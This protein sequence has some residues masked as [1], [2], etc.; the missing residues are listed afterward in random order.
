[1][2][3]GCIIRS[4]G[5]RTE[6]LCVEAVRRY[7]P[8]ENVDIVR[9]VRPFHMA[10]RRMFDIANGKDYDWY[11][12]LD[13]D[14]VLIDAW[15]NHVQD[16]VNN[17]K[18]DCHKIIFLVKDRFIAVPTFYGI[19]LYNHKYTNEAIRI[20]KRTQQDT[21]PEGN[22]RHHMSCPQF[23]YKKGILGYHGYLQYCKDIFA[24][25]ALRY[26]RDKSYVIK[27]QVFKDMDEEKRIAKMGWEYAQS[28][29]MDFTD[30]A[31]RDKF[32]GKFTELP[33]LD[34]SLD[35]FYKQFGDKE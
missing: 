12:G 4:V 28:N 3:F 5:E 20:L 33:E 13:A 18:G 21:K 19:H 16:A 31:I 10:V 30:F 22:L 32:S 24:R 15:L 25:F 7:L 1:M 34:M 14:V 9:N 27:H 23:L 11:L 26:S 17:L 29:K 8:E 6:N 2:K 35:E